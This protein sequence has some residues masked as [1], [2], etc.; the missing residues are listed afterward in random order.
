[1]FVHFLPIPPDDSEKRLRWRAL[2]ACSHRFCLTA[3]TAKD[4]RHCLN[5]SQQVIRLL[6]FPWPSMGRFRTGNVEEA[7]GICL[8]L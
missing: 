6:P 7:S 2:A 4:A 1:M 8:K 5:E 3:L